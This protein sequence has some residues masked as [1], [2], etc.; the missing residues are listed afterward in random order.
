MSALVTEFRIAIACVLVGLSVAVALSVGRYGFLMNMAFFWGSQLAVV[1]CAL[2]FKPRPITVAGLALALAV[3]L[4]AFATWAFTRIHPEELVW[5]GY[6]FSLPGAIVGAG[7]ARAYLHNHLRL[8]LLLSGAVSLG[9]A[10]AGIAVSQAVVCS[11]VMY[12]GGK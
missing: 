6:S 12:C 11:T 2:L 10:L 4:T 5:L 9:C 1:A 7:I 8:G 3:Y